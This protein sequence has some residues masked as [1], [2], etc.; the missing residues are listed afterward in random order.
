MKCFKILPTAMALTMVVGLAA[1]S[2][3]QTGQGCGTPNEAE[4]LFRQMEAQVA[5]AKTL[6]CEFD[7]KVDG[8][9]YYSK[10][11]CFWRTETKCGWR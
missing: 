5:K 11:N 6:A 8:T 3:A 4:K 10:G 1:L 9:N 2:P 7:I